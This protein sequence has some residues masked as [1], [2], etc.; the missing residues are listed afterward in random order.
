MAAVLAAALSLLPCATC[1]TT[2]AAP[3]LAYRPL[4]AQAAIRRCT[5]ALLA[6]G[7]GE[8]GEDPATASRSGNPLLLAA[9]AAVVLSVAAHAPAFSTFASQWSAIGAAGVHGEEFWS[10]LRFWSFFAFGHVLLKPAVWIGEVLHTSP[11]PLIGIFPLS[12]LAANIAVLG[13]LATQPKLRSALS[14]LLLACAIN[15]IGSG[16]DGSVNNADYNLA[17]DDGVKGC[18]AYEQVRMPSMDGFDIA[19]Y[20]GRW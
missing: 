12:F 18:P 15:F 4:L 14:V 8:P 1:L 17:L 10:A 2:L 19:K 6:A 11:G 13:V 9:G 20:D 16:L 7:A 3:G 5:S